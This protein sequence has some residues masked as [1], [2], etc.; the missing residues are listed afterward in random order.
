MLQVTVALDYVHK[1]GWGHSDVKPP[2]IFITPDGN[3]DLGDYGAMRK[4]GK[5]ADEKTAQFVPSDAP[6]SVDHA[7]KHLDKSL[8]AVTVLQ[9]LGL[10]KL[11]GRSG[12]SY[13]AIQEA[14]AKIENQALRFRLEGLVLAA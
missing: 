10:L 8:L 3:F 1:R 7:S 4:L 13:A 14:V 9:K 11:K 2:N 12:P 5:D 6:F